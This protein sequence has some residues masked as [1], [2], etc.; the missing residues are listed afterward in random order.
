MK[1]KILVILALMI[2]APSISLFAQDVDRT[3]PPQLPAPKP[4]TV[5]AIQ[6]FTLS[7]GLKVVLMEKHE[8]PLIQLNIIVKVGSVNDPADKVGLTNLTLDMMDEGA[9]GKSSLELAD[10]IDFLGAKIQT[11][12]WFHKS[13]VYLH[14]PL[15]KFDDALKIARDILLHPDFPKAELDRKKKDRLT[16]LMQMHDQPTEIASA[17][18][19]SLLFGADHPYGRMTNE[20]SIK[21]FSVDDLKS[22]Y[23]K[24]FVANNAYVVCVGDI[25]V[26]ELK[27]KLE[28][29]LGA[30]KKGN[31]DE[32]KINTSVQVAKRVVYIIDKPGAAQSV[33]NI[34]RI[35]PE[36]LTENYNAL[37]VMN[38]ILGGSFTSRLNN[39]LR[40]V[41]GYTYGASSRFN[42]RPIPGS[43]V[44]SSSVQTDVTDKALTEFFKELNGIRVPFTNDDLNRGKNL[45]A[46]SYPGNFQEVS[47]IA[48][49]IDEMIQYNLPANYFNNYVSSML[50][51]K[52]DE[53]NAVA[54][55]YIVPDKMIVVVVGDKAKIEEGIKALNL[56]EIKNLTIDDVLGKVPV[57]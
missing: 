12:S 1:K 27:A 37:V 21:S 38:T 43:F 19:N 11:A 48:P 8:V 29:V 15:S 56:G 44:A 9:A 4:L 7:N 24:Y 52:A 2:S 13:G 32:E 22:L 14:T 10:A 25:K 40:E 35:G 28:S 42:F 23:N 45:V 33:I 50:N 34:G 54:K 18:F 36:R 3:K 16:S 26:E 41:H 31:V 20:N 57:L 53:A 55:K 51:V 46:L 47:M 5:S 39:N 17:A 49:Q 6:Q 30:W